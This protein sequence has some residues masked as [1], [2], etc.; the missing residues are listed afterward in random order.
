MEYEFGI[1][2]NICKTLCTFQVQV[3]RPKKMLK[4][5]GSGLDEFR[6]LRKICHMSV[7]NRMNLKFIHLKELFATRGIVL[8]CGLVFLT[9]I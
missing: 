9:I 3:N 8:Q 6:I 4:L 2:K 5:R 7:G 1:F